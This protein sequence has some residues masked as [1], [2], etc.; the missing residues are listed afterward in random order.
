PVAPIDSSYLRIAHGVDTPQIASTYSDF[1]GLRTH[2][3][4]AY[5]DGSNSNREARFSP[6]DLGVDR[7]AYLY[8]YFTGKGEVVNPPDALRKPIVGGSLYLVMAPIG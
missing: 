4:F 1:G 5:V 2:Y 6:S 8:D 7:P 3:V